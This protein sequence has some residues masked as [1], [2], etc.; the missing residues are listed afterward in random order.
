MG[1]FLAMAFFAGAFFAVA[2]LVVVFLAAVF[3]VAVFFVGR[4]VRVFAAAD[5]R[6]RAFGLVPV[7]DAERERDGEGFFAAIFFFGDVEREV[8]IGIVCPSR[9]C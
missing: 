8:F 9:A 5:A 6:E 4:A 2:F 7:R 3:T 1:V